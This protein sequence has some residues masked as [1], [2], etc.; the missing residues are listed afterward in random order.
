MENIDLNKLG[1]TSLNDAEMNEC[2]GGLIWAAI[3]LL[4]GIIIGIC[5]T[6]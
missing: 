3:G 2:S 6:L 1:V 4:V 5:S